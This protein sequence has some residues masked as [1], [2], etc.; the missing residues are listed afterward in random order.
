MSKLRGRIWMV[1]AVALLGLTVAC[2]NGEAASTPVGP[3]PS[4]P[5]APQAASP[6]QAQAQQPAPAIGA[7]AQPSSERPAAQVA[8]SSPPEGAEVGAPV[9]EAPVG[10]PVAAPVEEPASR[11][12]TVPVLASPLPA[13]AIVSPVGSTGAYGG[14]PLLQVGGSQSGIWVTGQGS[15]AVEP[16]LVLINIGVETMAV[17]VAEARAEAARAMAAIVDAVKAH[18][19]DDRDI[20]TRS[21]N[22]SPQYEY[23]EVRENGR[24]VRRQTLVGY[25][26]SNSAAIKVRDLDSVGVIID[27]VAEA[28]GNATRING[29]NFTI[30]DPKPFM[31]GLRETA[32]KEA[33]AKAEQFARLTGV[34]VGRLVFVSELGAGAPVI[35]EF[36]EVVFSRAAA[37]PLAP[38]SIS[39]GELQLSLSVQVV[40]EIQ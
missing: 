8:P 38:T 29:I 13:P 21:F 9:K 40:F 34:A 12:L 5:A 25:R 22:I 7:P 36:A 33:L 17:T 39:G 14:S 19:L 4:E 6:S 1:G 32:V 2:G 37:A 35:A 31:T 27:D 15:L 16:D 30:E 28:G 10:V 26:V 11:V 18:G 24:T 3:E 23:P 20:Q